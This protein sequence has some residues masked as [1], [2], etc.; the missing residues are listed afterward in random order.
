VYATGESFAEA[1]RAYLRAG[2][3][4]GDRLMWIGDDFAGRVGLAEAEDLLER[5]ALQLPTSCSY[6]ADPS[7]A[8]GEQYAFYDAATRQAR[9]DGYA[10]LCVVADGTPMA[11][12][13]ARAPELVRWEHLADRF[14]ADGAGMTAMCVYDGDRLPAATVTE[15]AGVHP[16]VRTIT[17]DA[18]FRTWFDGSEL[19]L[20]GCVDTF[21]ADRLGAVLA[22]TVA[23]GSVARLDLSALEYADA[24]AVRA[25]AG[26]AD[27]R[28]ADGV[29]VQ[30]LGA[31]RF[32]C[33]IWHLLG[34]AHNA[35][36]TFGE[37]AA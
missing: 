34:Y 8:R 15:L 14:I 16:W 29:R 17:E 7:F 13:P 31:P 9:A 36:V 33:R 20:A 11:E 26:W 10:G 28:Q 37:S 12:D 5:G 21:S 25:I 6:E 27:Q 30:L 24:A 3:A 32:F 22:S 35:G 23:D 4:R 18:P 2:L 19:R 1:A